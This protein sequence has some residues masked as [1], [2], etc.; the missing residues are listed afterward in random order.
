MALVGYRD[1]DWLKARV[2]PADLGEDASWDGDLTTM[3]QAVAELFDSYTGRRLR[4]EE[5]RVFETSADQ[6][7]V[8]A[9]L[10]PIEEVSAAK[11]VVN[12]VESDIMDAI[13]AVRK[14]SGIVEFHG[15][16][17]VGPDLIRLT[18]TGGYWCRDG[19]ADE[20]PEGSAALP[21][22]LLGAWLHQVRAMCEAQNVFRAKGAEKPAAKTAALGLDTLDLVAVVRRTL[23]LYI[24]F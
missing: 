6:E 5:G 13:A 21:D 15:A 20:Q 9:D 16:P 22:D 8:I 3:G 19:E 1:L 18:L 7:A 4:R 17:S 23:Q 14:A 2:L 24:R 10:Y 11:L 12:G